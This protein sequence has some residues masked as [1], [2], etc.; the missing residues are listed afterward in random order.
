MQ[1]LASVVAEDP[2]KQTWL[3]SAGILPVMERLALHPDAALEPQAFL[4]KY[5]S[6]SSSSGGGRAA[7][8]GGSSSSGDAGGGDGG[9][10]SL[11]ARIGRTFWG[12]KGSSTSDSNAAAAAA[13][14]DATGAPEGSASGGQS[15]VQRDAQSGGVTAAAGAALGGCVPASS[16]AASGP[17]VS[18]A[19]SNQQQHLQQQRY[20][21][22][23]QKQH[24]QDQQQQLQ[25]NQ[26]QKVEPGAAVTRRTQQLSTLLLSGL[27]NELDFSSSIN[28]DSSSTHSHP[29]AAAA[30]ASVSGRLADAVQSRFTAAAL[31][32]PRSAQQHPDTTAGAAAGRPGTGPDTSQQQRQQQHYH[33]HSSSSSAAMLM[34]FAQGAAGWDEVDLAPVAVSRLNGPGSRHNGASGDQPGSDATTV[35]QV[36]A[37]NAAV[38]TA[39]A[40]EGASWADGDGLTLLC[41]QRQVARILSMLALQPAAAQQLTEAV[42]HLPG[43][44]AGLLLQ[45]GDGADAWARQQKQVHAPAAAVGVLRSGSRT[46]MSQ[47][48]AAPGAAAAASAA[49]AAGGVTSTAAWLPWLLEAAASQDCLLSSYAAKAL[50]HLESA[51]A[52]SGSRRRQQQQQY[53]EA[54]LQRAQGGGDAGAAAAAAAAAA[55]AA[56]AGSGNS[57]WGRRLYQ[58][59][60]SSEDLSQLV[61]GL[62]P[63]SSSSSAGEDGSQAIRPPVY[64]PDGIHLMHPTDGHNWGL[65][66]PPPLS[67]IDSLSAAA[68]SAASAAA[69]VA[70]SDLSHSDIDVGVDVP[71][72][73]PGSSSGDSSAAAVAAAA[74]AVANAAAAAAAAAAA[75]ALGAEVGQVSPGDTSSTGSISISTAE[76]KAA[77]AVAAGSSSSST[78]ATAAG[79]VGFL[80]PAVSWLAQRLVKFAEIKEEEA[81]QALQEAAAAGPHPSAAGNP[82]A[83]L[84]TYQAV[85]ALVDRGKDSSSIGGGSMAPSGKL[86]AGPLT[87]NP[88]QQQGQQ[89]QQVQQQQGGEVEEV[90]QSV[91]QP[92]PPEV[93]IVF[94]HGIRGGPFVSWRKGTAPSDP[95]LSGAAPEHDSS[96]VAAAVVGGTISSSSSSS[97]SR[98]VKRKGV[99]LKPSSAA[100]V[101]SR[102]M[103]QEDCWPAAWLAADVPTARLLTVEYKV[104]VFETS[105]RPVLLDSLCVSL[106]CCSRRDDGLRLCVS[107]QNHAGSVQLLPRALHSVFAAN[108]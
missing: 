80:Q 77:A 76:G 84:A 28:S 96:V 22:S 14:A 78:A 65:L 99:A 36:L 66:Q 62:W 1:L 56:A 107:A 38:I 105:R 17:A 55:G 23:A 41:L 33:Q 18:A 88:Q 48:A 86:S 2:S 74:S 67:L 79:D 34:E 46:S 37:D 42:Q 39:A 53:M 92:A 43:G 30:V 25:Y 106:P 91:E 21:A 60:R 85:Q 32:S 8:K 94:V 50:L 4:T 95:S 93:D 20:T 3:L 90:V 104:G 71:P 101:H 102:H 87:H 29:A 57:T 10:G 51:V 27:A 19:P 69:A 40:E 49:T 100:A 83:P 44:A 24:S 13:G 6:S 5:D 89:V 81:Q 98:G 72:P 103:T 31:V 82:G 58:E 61:E 7:G 15:R 64:Y 35:P 12:W 70:A 59:L 9:S 52:Y 16:V 68:A 54:L 63:F 75:S 26:G 108:S 97:G 11:S 47:V 73:S 45:N